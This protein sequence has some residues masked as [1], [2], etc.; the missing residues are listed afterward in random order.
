MDRLDRTTREKMTRMS[1]RGIVDDRTL[2]PGFYWRPTS[3][4]PYGKD[5][6]PMDR[7]DGIV[8]H[9][10]VNRALVPATG[11]SDIWGWVNS[12]GSC[13]VYDDMN[14]AGEQYKPFGRIAYGQSNGNNHLCVYESWDG[15]HADTELNDQ[16]QGSNESV[17]TPEQC[18]RHADVAAF[19]ILNWD[20]PGR[21][22][23]TSKQSERGIGFHRL[24][25]DNWR[26]DIY[27]GG[28]SWTQHPGKSCPG[29]LRIAQIP[30][31]VARAN[32]LVVAFQNGSADYLPVGDVDLNFALTRGG[33]TP[34]PPT[35]P[36]LLEKLMSLDPQ[37]L[38]D[39]WNEYARQRSAALNDSLGEKHGF[40][41][42][43][44]NISHGLNWDGSKKK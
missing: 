40:A 1:N 44:N 17:W 36:T 27:G 22:M 14:G 12:E 4:D 43:S 31:I 28:D 10:A 34:V 20:T 35:D 18:E 29:D 21:V 3:G 38:K 11:L 39:F 15:L 6:G 13:H 19:F 26:T 2:Y 37:E 16:G 24:G 30:G 25:V 7:V 8:F 5:I 42:Q 23:E 41:I 9:E 33:G 32:A